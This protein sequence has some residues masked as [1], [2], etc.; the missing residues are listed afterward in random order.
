LL[1]GVISLLTDAASETAIVVLPAFLASLG[2]GALA[3]G[4]IEGVAEAVA[5]LLKLVAGRWADRLG[6]H[7]P[8]VIAGY[9]LSSSVRPLF[10]LALAPW[11]VLAVRVVDRVGK[12]LRT[13]PRDALLAASV[14]PAHRGAAFGWHRAMDHAGAVIGPLFATAYLARSQDLRTLLWLTAIPGIAVVLVAWRVRDVAPAPSPAAK[15][16]EKEPV[17]HGLARVLVPVALFALGNASDTFLLLLVVKKSAS[18]FIGPLLWMG[19]HMVKVA[20]S[21]YGGRLADHW[22][23]RRTILLGWSVYAAVYLG[24]AFAS[25]LRQIAALFIAYG[26]Y[27][28][29]CEGAEKAL[30]AEVVPARQRGTA[31]GWYHLSQGAVLLVANVAFGAVWTAWGSRVAFSVSAGLAAIAATMFA[32]LASSRR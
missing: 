23:K 24:F 5:S 32:L 4:W 20:T 10:A 7:R 1:L 21:V 27:H 25:D 13:S 19:L 16:E 30:V 8:F 17:A 28:G 14:D 3:L 9:S 22:G 11:H 2:A 31:F 12:G 26:A 6:K 18:P 29:L 15:G